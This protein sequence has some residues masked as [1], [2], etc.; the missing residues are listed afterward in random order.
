MLKLVPVRFAFAAAL[1]IVCVIASVSSVMAQVVQ[2]KTVPVGIYS[3]DDYNM[4]SSSYVDGVLIRTSWEACEPTQGKY[5]FSRIAKIVSYARSKGKKVTIAMLT[6][7]TPKWLLA[8]TTIAT[9]TGPNGKV[10][11]PWDTKAQG[12]FEKLIAAMSA[13]VV[14]GYALKDHPSVANI[15]TTILGADSLRVVTPLSTAD[16]A[17]FKDGVW[18]SIAIWRKY[19]TSTSKAYYVGMFAMAGSTGLS[20]TRDIRDSILAQFPDT[21]FYQELLTGKSP[22]GPLFDMVNEVK[23]KTSVMFQWYGVITEQNTTWKNGDWV[24]NAQGVNVDTPGLGFSHGYYDLGAK[25]FECYPT[26]LKNSAYTADYQS[27]YKIIHG[28]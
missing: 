15:N 20:S 12:L 6:F 25:Y 13:T 22:N 9:M 17:K 2:S 1:L 7:R 11:A 27:W 23:S 24:K 16:T 10:P 14:D 5:D 28:K 21:N 8:D 3:I 19:F 18:E 4:L 26:D